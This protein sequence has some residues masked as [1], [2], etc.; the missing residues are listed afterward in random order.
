MKYLNKTIFAIETENHKKVV[1]FLGYGY[2][3]EE[4]ENNSEKKFRFVEYTFAYAKLS[5]VLKK[6]FERCEVASATFVTQYVTDVTLEEL[7]NIYETYDNGHRPKEVCQLSEDLP[8]GI[9]I[10][11]GSGTNQGG[12]VMRLPKNI[13]VTFEELGCS[14]EDYLNDTYGFSDTVANYLSDTYG[15]CVFDFDCSARKNN[16]GILEAVV[17]NIHWDTSN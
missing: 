11:M 14:K 5:N 13:T 9:Y 17:T 10:Y 8:T 2:L 16:D 7:N 15:L 6:G 4:M 3:D 1:H 12:N